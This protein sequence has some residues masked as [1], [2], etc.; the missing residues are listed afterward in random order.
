[1]VPLPSLLKLT[2][3][4]PICHEDDDSKELLFRGKGSSPTDRRSTASGQQ[5]RTT[6]Q[7]KPEQK[8]SRRLRDGL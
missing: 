5:E 6:E 3:Q 7:A 2:D 8:N 1:M 4:Q